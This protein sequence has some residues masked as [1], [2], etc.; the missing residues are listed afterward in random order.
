MRTEGAPINNHSETKLQAARAERKEVW[1]A[2]SQR[3]IGARYGFGKK[4]ALVVI[5]MANAFNDPSHPIGADQDSTVD[6]IADLLEVARSVSLRRY[7]FTTAYHEDLHDAGT[8]VQKVPV[9]GTL[10]LGTTEVEIDPRL[11][12]R[13]DE[14]LVVKKASSCF[15]GTPFD[16]WL[17][18][19]GV[20]T[21]I[22]TGCSTSGCVRATCLDAASHG[23]RVIVPEECV[24][25]RLEVVHRANLFDID[26]KYADVMPNEE[27]L[28][29]VAGMGTQ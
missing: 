10:R 29:M 11:G 20:D 12:I 16:T 3:G 13:D 23:L 14:P 28:A 2:Y 25:D 26:S 24:S 9:V 27:V 8:W 15:F 6:A 4:T 22:V 1:E 5:D 17:R 19:E 21:L 7:F 18:S